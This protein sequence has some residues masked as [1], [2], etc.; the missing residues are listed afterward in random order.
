MP[1]LLREL[2]LDAFD[3]LFEPGEALEQ[4]LP[5]DAV[6]GDEQQVFVAQQFAEEPAQLGV[7]VREARRRARR[8]IFGGAAPVEGALA[9]AAAVG[10]GVQAAHA[11]MLPAAA[12]GAELRPGTTRGRQ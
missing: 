1:T 9:G 8:A 5:R 3:A 12:D 10:A 2:V 4:E 6:A 11:A 7:G